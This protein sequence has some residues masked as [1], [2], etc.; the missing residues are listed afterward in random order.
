[1]EEE[2]G[3]QHSD[4]L[5]IW[6]E[7]GKMLARRIFRRKKNWLCCIGG[8]F[9]FFLRK[10]RENIS[11]NTRDTFH[12]PKTKGKMPKRKTAINK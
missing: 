5:K 3:V 6:Q 7:M 9:F 2:D 11:Q 10:R 1:M 8:F 4:L 12:N